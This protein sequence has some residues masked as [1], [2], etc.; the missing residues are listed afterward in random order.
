MSGLR[1]HSALQV[2]E[3]FPDLQSDMLARAADVPPLDFVTM[4]EN[5][6]TP[7]DAITFCAY[8]LDRRKAVWW[9]LECKK[10]LG[11]D[12]NREDEVAVRTAEAWVREPEEHRRLAALD[13]GLTGD[14][15]LVGTWIALAAGSSGGTLRT[16]DLPGPPIP[17]KICASAVRTSVLVGLS[18]IPARDRK[19]LLTKCVQLFRDLAK[20][21]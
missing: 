10:L 3:T 19:A 11:L 21:L 2:F 1:F 6:P 16:G 17:P 5:S 20:G 14:R 15:G 4:I 8:V 18:M 12:S 9:A 13:I 7:E